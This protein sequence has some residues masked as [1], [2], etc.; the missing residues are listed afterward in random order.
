MSEWPAA[1]DDYRCERRTRPSQRSSAPSLYGRRKCSRTV[2]IT[3]DARHSR[4]RIPSLAIQLPQTTHRSRGVFT[5][6]D[7]IVSLYHSFPFLIPLDC[8]PP[9]SLRSLS[10]L[11]PSTAGRDC[12]HPLLPRS[13]LL[14][15]WTPAPLA[16]RATRSMHRS[17]FRATTGEGEERETA[18]LTA[19]TQRP[20]R[21]DYFR[22]LMEPT[23][24]GLLPL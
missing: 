7:I 19:R 10:H 4:Q 24:E 22:P 12:D 15:H 18:R 23:H 14:P 11:Y 16:L 5:V 2:T 3:T 9:G 21:N 1:R 17:Q 6:F 13:P 20:H 8:E